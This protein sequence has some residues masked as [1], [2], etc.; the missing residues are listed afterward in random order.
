MQFGS[1]LLLLR[2]PEQP[3]QPERLPS[4]VPA[5]GAWLVGLAA[6]LVAAPAGAIQ[7]DVGVD[8]STDARLHTINDGQPGAQWN[9]GGTG[10]GGDIDYDATNEEFVLTGVLDTMN[11]FDPNDGS[12]PNST[13]NCSFDF[14]PDLDLTLEGSFDSIVVTSLGSGFLGVDALF[15]TTS[16]GAPDMTLTDPSDT[17][18]GTLLEADWQAGNFQGQPTSGLKVSVT[19]DTNTNSVVGSTSAIGFLDVDPTS[20]YA[21]LFESGGDFFQL[22]VG[23]LF[24][25]SPTLDTIV[26]GAI[27]TGSLPDFTTEGQGQIFRTASG[28]FEVPEPSVVALLGVGLGGLA[29]MGRRRS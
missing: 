21:P 22:N 2:A 14:G 24:G 13:D 19:Y 28:D 12:C 17:G 16:D 8:A 25:F 10:A 23:Q 3:G 18:F 29:V 26:Q 7:F 11:Y 1:G 15:G 9:T 27:N 4:S 6:L 20:E 5:L